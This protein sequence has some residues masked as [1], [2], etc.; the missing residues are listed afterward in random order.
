MSLLRSS[1]T[2][3]LC[4]AAVAVPLAAVGTF[5]GNG[6]PVAC[7]LHQNGVAHVY[8]TGR[9]SNPHIV[10]SFNVTEQVIGLVVAATAADVDGD[11]FDELVLASAT[12]TGKWDADAVQALALSPDCQSARV[13]A[14]SGTVGK[15]MWEALVPLHTHEARATDLYAPMRVLAIQSNAPGAS[16]VNFSFSAP[17]YMDDVGESDYGIPPGATAADRL[18]WAALR[19]GFPIS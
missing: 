17:F 18:A 9:T 3:W 10:G 11:G 4:R 8:T 16:F 19:F 15:G 7:A 13:K 5:C 12:G 1:L 14:S 2:L 6:E